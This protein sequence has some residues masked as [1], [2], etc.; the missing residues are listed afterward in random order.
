MLG[1]WRLAHLRT[2]RLGSSHRFL[3][4]AREFQPHVLESLELTSSLCDGVEIA[5]PV[6]GCSNWKRPEFPRRW[7]CMSLCDGARIFHW[8]RPEFP[9]TIPKKAKMLTPIRTR[10][11]MTNTDQSM[12]RRWVPSCSTLKSWGY[13]LYIPYAR[14]RTRP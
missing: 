14:R 13:C 9:S 5:V 8:K 6:L 10:K 1:S 11:S 2:I 3:P 12:R 4:K 7:K